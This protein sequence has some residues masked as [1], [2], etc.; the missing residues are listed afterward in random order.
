MV[1]K[2][3]YIIPLIT[4]YFSEVRK[5]PKTPSSSYEVFPLLKGAPV[6]Y[7]LHSA[8][9]IHLKSLLPTE[10]WV[11]KGPLNQKKILNPV[12]RLI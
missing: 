4:D 12:F 2:C 8:L 10:F 9:H 5:F 1:Y 7:S 11:K 6:K 3:I